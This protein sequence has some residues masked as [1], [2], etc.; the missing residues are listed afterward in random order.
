MS[1]NNAPEQHYSITEPIQQ[2]AY[3][4]LVLPFRITEQ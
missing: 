3:T 1:T 4:K 2:Q